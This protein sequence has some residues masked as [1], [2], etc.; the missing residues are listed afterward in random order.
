MFLPRA[1]TIRATSKGELISVWDSQNCSGVTLGEAFAVKPPRI[2]R[3]FKT[4]R[5][6]MSIRSPYPTWTSGASRI[7]RSSRVNDKADRP[8]MP[9]A[10][11]RSRS[12]P[13]LT[14]ID[15]LQSENVRGSVRPS[16]PW[17]IAAASR[18]SV[19]SDVLADRSD[20]A[21]DNRSPIAW[22]LTNKYSHGQ[23]K[24]APRASEPQ[25]S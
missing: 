24:S 8:G 19:G 25:S 13:L 6:A 17:T 10:R 20:R 11:Q 12:V 9:A 5:S 23:T 14:P 4:R 3:R 2:S 18:S 1:R 15:R 22:N 21:R 16:L 7:A